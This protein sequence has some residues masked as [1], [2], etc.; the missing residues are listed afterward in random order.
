MCAVV[1][2]LAYLMRHHRADDAYITYRYAKNLLA[3][4]GFV[5]NPGEP[6]LATTSPLHAL[7]LALVGAFY[8]NLPVAA[9][10]LSA[11]AALALAA[12]VYL[13]L[14][15]QDAPRAGV[16]SALL[17][18]TCVH[19]YLFAPLET[20]LV[21][22]LCWALILAYLAD[23]W[24]AVS[25]IGA[26]ALVA[27]LDTGLLLAVL[28]LAHLLRHRRP[29]FLL[30]RGA[31]MLAIAS[32]W[33]L[34]ATLTYG[35]PLPSTAAAK[36]GWSGHI[37]TWIASAWPKLLATLALGNPVASLVV[38]ALAA[39]GLARIAAD[40]RQRRLWVVPAWLAAYAAAY[41]LLRIPYPFTWYYFPLAC[42][43][44]F[45][46]GL[47]ADTLLHLVERRL[48]PTARRI[49]RLAAA[50]ALAGVVVGQALTVRGVASRLPEEKWSG[51]RDAIYRQVAAWLATHAPP[52]AS[53]AMC[54][55]GAIAY[56]SDVRVIDLW[57]LVTP[58]VVE[59]V[60]R[61]DKEWA[62]DAYRPDYVVVHYRA[63]GTPPGPSEWLDRDYPDY[64]LAHSFETAAYPFAI[65][66]YR[67]KPKASG[68]QA[69]AA[70]PVN[71]PR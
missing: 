21:A 61:G 37:A 19:T 56:Y 41:S 29:G 40:E 8:G 45:L 16:V 44:L 50:V 49:L 33:F 10:A 11:V 6:V 14:E 64:A 28:F 62:I 52:G 32:P 55:V 47:G 30:G 24:W 5:F 7:L 38:L 46:A 63:K 1:P 3:G 69:T 12:A 67:R 39:V 20:V 17:I 43:A 59:H 26:L 31:A 34:Y 65:D 57:G 53:V 51:A 66:L 42:G 22:A 25:A 27:R 71:A 2:L 23:R 68:A 58:A 70:G 36:S 60:K 18:A 4:R 13:I 48:E 15:R 9:N 35:S 54:E